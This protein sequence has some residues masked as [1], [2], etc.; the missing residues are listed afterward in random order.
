MCIE[1]GY[2]I[3][4]CVA[5]KAQAA[6]G[7]NP[8]HTGSPVLAVAKDAVVHVVLAVRPTETLSALTAVRLA[9]RPT[10][11]AVLAR[12]RQ[13]A[14]SVH[15]A[16]VALEEVRTCA[17]VPVR[18]VPARAV[19]PARAARAFVEVPFARDSRESF[20]AAAIEPGRDVVRGV[21][22]AL[23][24]RSAVL[25]RVGQTFVDVRFAA[26]AGETV[27]A[28]AGEV[29]GVAGGVEQ[30]G[31]SVEARV[32]Q[33]AVHWRF[34]PLAR[35]VN[36]T[37]APESRTIASAL[38]CIQTRR[39]KTEIE[40]LTVHSVVSRQTVARIGLW[41]YHTCGVVKTPVSLAEVES[42]TQ[43]SHIVFR[44]LTLKIIVGFVGNASSTI[45][46]RLR[47]ADI[48]VFTAIPEI[49]VRAETLERAHQ[50][51]TVAVVITR[52]ADAIVRVDVTVPPL[53]AR[54]T[55]AGVVATPQGNTADRG[56]LGTGVSFA[57]LELRFTK[58][59]RP[60]GRTSAR[61]GAMF[62]H[63]SS[64][65]QTAVSIAVIHALYTLR[66][67]PTLQ[68]GARENVP[69]VKAVRVGRTWV[70]VTDSVAMATRLQ[71]F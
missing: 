67:L 1:T 42:L 10:R 54:Q 18:F 5:R 27:P 58:R 45:K 24:A 56:L 49:G 15:L 47:R 44:T 43:I 60:P 22:V 55:V 7:L 6:V 3:L 41:L 36:R 11:P 33:T 70:D 66:P 4:T 35:V 25:A 68:T 19:V 30:T 9:L 62:V 23:N 64:V 38:G 40:E 69:V 52:V 57:R 17:V 50:V 46:T 48:H 34:A 13:A 53:P 37:Q 16:V 29:R 2:D 32:E 51:S 8:I 21:G 31:R 61:V 39:T 59:S 63:A 20:R 26:G 28:H 71:V 12:A 14:P 65:I